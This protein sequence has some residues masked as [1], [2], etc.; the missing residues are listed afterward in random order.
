MSSKEIINKRIEEVKQTLKGA[1]ICCFQEV[2]KQCK[3]EIKQYN[4]VLK[5]LEILEA[6]KKLLKECL[7]E[8]YYNECYDADVF[9]TKATTFVVA[10]VPNYKSEGDLI[11]EWL[12]DERPRD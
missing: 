11:R 10:R 2:E 6:L 4:Q 9:L 1:E 12:L 8:W 7:I 3:E 5:D